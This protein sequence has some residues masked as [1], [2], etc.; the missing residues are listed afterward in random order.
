MHL[1]RLASL[2]F[3]MSLLCL[4]CT[5][6]PEDSRVILSARALAAF[7]PLP[8]ASQESLPVEVPSSAN[9][10]GQ[11]ASINAANIQQG[12]QEQPDHG[13]QS[14]DSMKGGLMPQVNRDMNIAGNL[15]AWP[16]KPSR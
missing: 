11:V 10:N 12:Q 3:A 5:E 8:A 7:A 6:R 14:V 1:S 4:G 2:L 16:P 13:V 15:G 9:D